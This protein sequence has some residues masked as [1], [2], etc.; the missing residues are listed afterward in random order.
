MIYSHSH[1]FL[2]SCFPLFYCHTYENMFL[3]H[4]PSSCMIL[5]H[6]IATGDYCCRPEGGARIQRA[7]C[8]IAGVFTFFF[9]FHLSNENI[10]GD[11]VGGGDLWRALQF[12]LACLLFRKMPGHT[13]HP[14]P[15]LRPWAIQLRN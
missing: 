4:S 8:G 14:T 1:S 2:S 13:S 5:P 7:E 15:F 3:F 9:I 6:N 10:T 12:C 11:P